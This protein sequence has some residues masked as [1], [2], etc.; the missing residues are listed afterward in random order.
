MKPA[1]I[2]KLIDPALAELKRELAMVI[3]EYAN[4]IVAEVRTATLDGVRARLTGG[5]M[6]PEPEQEVAAEKPV[7]KRRRRKQ[8]RARR[9]LPPF[10]PRRSGLRPEMSL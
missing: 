1:D 4:A 6:A 5:G 7:K 2:A 9:R 10:R 8:G 3:A